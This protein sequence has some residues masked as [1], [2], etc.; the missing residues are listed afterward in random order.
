MAPRHRVHA[1]RNGCRRA[2]KAPIIIM[3]ESLQAFDAWFRRDDVRSFHLSVAAWPFPQARPSGNGWAG[4]RSWHFIVT[5]LI[6][7]SAIVLRG[8]AI[9][10]NTQTVQCVT[11]VSAQ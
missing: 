11:A 2:D 10:Y 7:L 4:R 3:P 5:R 9:Y 1:P 6:T 8:P